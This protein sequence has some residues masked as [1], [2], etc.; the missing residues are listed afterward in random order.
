MRGNK[1]SKSKRQKYSAHVWYLL[2]GFLQTF[3]V[4]GDEWAGYLQV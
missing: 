4:S 3:K 2:M 1:A